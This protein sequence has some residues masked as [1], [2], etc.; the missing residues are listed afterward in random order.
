MHQIL[1]SILLQQPLINLN[2]NKGIHRRIVQLRLPQRPSLPV[3]ECLR[4]ADFLPEHSL[5]DVAEVRLFLLWVQAFED[6]PGVDDALHGFL[7]F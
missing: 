1:L 3:R 5:A 4:F 6:L 7:E 2:H